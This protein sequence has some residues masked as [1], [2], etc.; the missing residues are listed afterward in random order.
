MSAIDLWTACGTRVYLLNGPR[1]SNVVSWEH[2]TIKMRSHVLSYVSGQPERAQLIVDVLQQNIG[3]MD[4]RA[5]WAAV[6]ILKNA[7]EW[8]SEESTRTFYRFLRSQLE[9]MLTLEELRLAP[10]RAQ[11]GREPGEPAL[12]KGSTGGLH[13]VNRKHRKRAQNRL[14][15]KIRATTLKMQEF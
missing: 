1:T 4:A 5:A 6:G 10:F 11:K 9:P 3:L 2:V 7:E 12:S 15:D 8:M 13:G 14:R